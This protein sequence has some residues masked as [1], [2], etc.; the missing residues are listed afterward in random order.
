MG[1]DSRLYLRLLRY[2]KPYWKVAAVSVL[3]MLCTAALEPT[4]PALMQPLIDKSLIGKDS[5]SIWLIPLLILLAFLAKGVA[6][7]VANVSSQY[8][9]Q[10]AMED[11]RQAVFAQELDL[12]ISVHEQQG[13]G[14]M[15]SR[16]TYDTAMVGDAVASAWIVLIRDSLVIL[17]LC[18]FLLYTSWMLT[19]VVLF[20]APLVALVLRYA[21]IRIRQS[22]QRIQIMMGSLSAFITEA[23]L[24]LKEIKIFNSQESQEKRFSEINSKLRREQMRIARIQSLNVPLVQILAAST[25]ALVIYLA[26]RMSA[27]DLLS[28]GEFVAFITAVSMIFEPVRRL[29]NVNAV[30]Q[31]GLAGAQSIF[32]L[33]DQSGEKSKRIEDQYVEVSFGRQLGGRIEFRNVSFSYPGKRAVVIENFNLCIEPGE[34]VALVGPSGSGKSTLIHLLARF[35]DP[36]NGEIFLDNR[37]VTECSIAALR[38][39]LSLVSQHVF[40]FE[41][42]IRDNIVMGNQNASDSAIIDAAKY[43]NAWEFIEKLPAGLETELGSL[44]NS[45][46]GGQRQRIA[47]ARAFLK[48]APILLLDEPTSALDLKSEQAVID[49]L[50]QLIKGRTTIFIS[51]KPLPPLLVNRTIQLC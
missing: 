5:R 8:V 31:R 21:G 44:G 9:A 23:L 13:S 27:S 37:P 14:N 33:M 11:I 19:I 26:S 45:L 41:G 18:S 49:G 38:S 12:P 43:S 15:L 34:S 47:I 1:L 32:W 29:T 3:A 20:S 7:Y 36:S 22:N 28:P 51:H 24:G 6:E 46:S 16:I 42:S 17:G 10:R 50:T 30:L 35:I 25:V 48:N 39:K 40:L 2:A 4:I